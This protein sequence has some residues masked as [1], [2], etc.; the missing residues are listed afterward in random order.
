MIWS[1]PSSLTLIVAMTAPRFTAVIVPVGWLR[2]ERRMGR[3]YAYPGEVELAALRL[4][5]R[6]GVTCG[7]SVAVVASALLNP[8]YG[9]RLS[10]RAWFDDEQGRVHDLVNRIWPQHLGTT[11]MGVARAISDH[12]GM[13]YRWRLW[14]GRRDRLTDV[15]EAVDAELPVAM[16]VGRLVPRHWVLLV[17]RDRLRTP[18]VVSCYEPSSG[19]VR[20]VELDAIRTATLTN[21]GFPRPYAF[22][23][24]VSGSN[25]TTRSATLSTDRRRHPPDSA[26]AGSATSSP[27]PRRGRLPGGRSAG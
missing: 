8:S 6:D 13:P 11:P 12:S 22:A 20:A 15:L 21:V 24:P 2:I 19:Q 25:A 18:G 1:E 10:G 5:Q 27:R 3:A 16:L 26:P 4:T 7:P 14:R 23:L 9:Q 17:S